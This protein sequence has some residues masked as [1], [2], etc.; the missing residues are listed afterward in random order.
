M[1]HMVVEKILLNF[2]LFYFVYFKTYKN[3]ESNKN[4]TKNIK[5][6]KI[7][8]WDDLAKCQDELARP[9]WPLPILSMFSEV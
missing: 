7:S 5:I 4:V 2:I 1:F 3:R 6:L 9:V 8:R